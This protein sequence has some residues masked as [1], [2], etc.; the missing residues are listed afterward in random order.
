MNKLNSQRAQ[1]G[2]PRGIG[3]FNKD[4]PV[5]GVRDYHEL[6]VSRDEQFGVVIAPKLEKE[7]CVIDFI[8]VPVQLKG[9]L[10]F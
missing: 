1:S 5:D 6:V 10:R 7:S 3:T 2:G 4:F 8:E 9:F